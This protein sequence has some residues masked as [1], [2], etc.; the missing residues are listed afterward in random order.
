MMM[1][2]ANETK[3]KSYW[4]VLLGKELYVFR[5]ENDQNHKGMNSL[6]G[7]FLVPLPTEQY[8]GKTLF[9]FRL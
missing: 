2:R 5:K 7:V 4:Y 6:V 3:L 9:P 8:E 1:R